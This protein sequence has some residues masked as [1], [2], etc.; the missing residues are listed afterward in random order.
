MTVITEHIQSIA[1]IDDNTVITFRSPTVRD[2]DDDTAMITP[3][4]VQ[5]TADAGVLTTP[6]LA[7]G[8]AIVAVGIAEYTID[9]P[10]SSTPVR[11]WD[12]IQEGLPVPPAQMATAVIN[13]GGVSVARA[14][15]ADDY[16]AYVSTTTPIPGSIFYV[17]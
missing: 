4:M 6:D 17:Y 10:D 7:P 3:W 14:M 2:S 15:T 5:F 12:L 9:I 8:P 11:L 1:G 13:G 16:A